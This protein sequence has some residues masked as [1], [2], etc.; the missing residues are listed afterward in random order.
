MDIE[1]KTYCPMYKSDLVELWWD[2]LNIYPGNSREEALQAFR[3]FRDNSKTCG[4]CEETGYSRFCQAVVMCKQS[5]E[6][7]E[8]GGKATVGKGRDGDP[9]AKEVGFGFDEAKG[10]QVG[11]GL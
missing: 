7:I 4:R 6:V 2:R 5:E 11:A 9:K 8:D 10:S 3:E 1:I